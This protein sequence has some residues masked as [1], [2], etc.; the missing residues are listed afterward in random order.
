MITNQVVGG[1]LLRING[2]WRGLIR[3]VIR[4]MRAN[5]VNVKARRRRARRLVEL[6]ELAGLVTSCG[7]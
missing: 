5:R 3:P 1:G 4:P 6:V 7:R 2:H